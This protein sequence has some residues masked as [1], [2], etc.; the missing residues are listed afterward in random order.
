MPGKPTPREQLA[1]D[2]HAAHR[3]AML[4]ASIPR[5]PTTIWSYLDSRERTRWLAVADLVL[6]DENRRRVNGLAGRRI[7]DEKAAA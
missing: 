4:P 2:L 5:N 6:S 3:Y 1:I 7:R